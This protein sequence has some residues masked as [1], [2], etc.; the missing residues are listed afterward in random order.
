L[1]C[2]DRSGAGET[3]GLD[4]VCGFPTPPRRTPQ[5]LREQ[6]RILLPSMAYRFALLSSPSRPTGLRDLRQAIVEP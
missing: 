3:G 4:A 2:A 6:Q 5:A 1:R